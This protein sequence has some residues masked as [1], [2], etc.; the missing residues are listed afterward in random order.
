MKEETK[1]NRILA[2]ERDRQVFFDAILNPPPANETLKAAMKE[3]K[4]TVSS[5]EEPY[6]LFLDDIRDP[7]MAHAYTKQAIYL[8]VEWVIA[9]NF[10]EFKNV[11]MLRG[12]PLVV[13]FDHDLADSHY[14]PEHLWTDY[15]ASKDWQDAQRHTEKTGLD[16]AK[17][18]IELCRTNDW[19][20]L[21][22]CLCHSQNPVGK[23]R[24]IAAITEYRRQWWTR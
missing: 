4:K 12:L 22:T 16:C 20:P 24:I 21:P 15:E 19:R 2:T 7:H 6:N 11:I 5:I 10:E 23:D 14:T 8:E 17:W 13:S 18:L 9:R 3:Y 1:R